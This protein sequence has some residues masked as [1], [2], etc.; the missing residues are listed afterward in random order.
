MMHMMTF[1]FPPNCL[2]LYSPPATQ[3]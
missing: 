2:L 3:C 1:K